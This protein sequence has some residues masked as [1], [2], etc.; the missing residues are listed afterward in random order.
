ML[1]FYHPQAR[2]AKQSTFLYDMK[3]KDVQKRSDLLGVCKISKVAMS[4]QGNRI[5][6]DATSWR[7]GSP[8]HGGGLP[9]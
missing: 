3:A 1:W 2:A 9:L 6:K 4:K 7:P 8:L 5:E